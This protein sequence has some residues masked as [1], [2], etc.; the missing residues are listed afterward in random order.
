MTQLIDLSEAQIAGRLANFGKVTALPFRL[1]DYGTKPFSICLVTKDADNFK[2]VE[3]ISL[4]G[5]KME[6]AAATAVRLND[7]CPHLIQE[8]PAGA[9]DLAKYDVYWA[10]HT[11]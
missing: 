2:T 11:V 3:I 4:R 5:A 1:G 7:Y 6:S 10:S 9:I 8:I